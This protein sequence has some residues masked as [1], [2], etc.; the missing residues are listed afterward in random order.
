MTQRLFVYGSL[1]PGRPNEHV[2]S[3]IGGTWEEASVRGYLKPQGWGAEIGYPLIIKPRDGAGA[4]GTSRVDDD[5]ALAQLCAALRGDEY[6]AIDTE[7]IRESTYYPVLALI[8]IA[9]EK[10]QACID[11]LAIT[12]FA[13]LAELLVDPELLKVF[14][15]PS[16]DLEILYQKFGEV[17]RP[18]FD[19]QLAAA[20][21]GLNHQASYAELVK[22]FTGVPVVTC[23]RSSVTPSIT[24]ETLLL[25]LWIATV[26][27]V[28]L[29]SAAAINSLPG[30]SRPR[31]VPS[32]IVNALA[33]PVSSA[34]TINRY[35][36]PSYRIEAAMPTHCGHG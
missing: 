24:P 31:L 11:P 18:I 27:T 1:G 22:Q 19:T 35:A 33:R 20:V 4:A 2:L 34:R 15:S 6:C 21:L 29:E 30:S 7:F 5:A 26:S 32:L 14:H 28:M 25:E 13:P 17:P 23:C 16:Q 36:L 12:D 3:A 10:R 9:S 8:Q